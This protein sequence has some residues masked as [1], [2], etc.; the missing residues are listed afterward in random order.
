MTL[1][2]EQSHHLAKV[3]RLARGARVRV[4]DGC[5]REWEARVIAA[6]R[7]AASLE[8]LGEVRPLPEPAVAVTLIAAV[9]RGKTMDALVHDATMLGVAAIVPVLSERVSVTRREAATGAAHARWRRIAVST[10]RQC[11]R[12]T[13]PGVLA[14]EPLDAAL[15]GVSAAVKLWLAEP[16]LAVEPRRRIDDLAEA[17]RGGGAALAIGPEGGWTAGEVERAAVSGFVPWSLGPLVLRAE[18]VPL[19]ALSVLRYAWSA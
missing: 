10:C 18:S 8:I 15:A 5:G 4:F 13:V 1:D 9:L 16:T 14:P 3:L 17:A 11:G 19:A 7:R 2:E 12:A 6:D